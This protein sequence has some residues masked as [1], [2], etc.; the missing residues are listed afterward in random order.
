M[1]LNVIHRGF[2]HRS[3]EGGRRRKD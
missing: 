3:G 1:K 2:L